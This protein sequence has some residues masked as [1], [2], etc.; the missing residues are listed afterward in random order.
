VNDDKLELKPDNGK[1][2]TWY[3]HDLQDNVAFWLGGS[4]YFREDECFVKSV[5]EGHN[6]EPSFYTASKVDQIIDQVKNR[7]DESE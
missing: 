3:R 1:S 2:F 7:V 5:V 4:E 6:A